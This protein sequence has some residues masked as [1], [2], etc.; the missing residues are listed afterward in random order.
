MNARLVA[1][2]NSTAA[3]PVIVI[4]GPDGCGKSTFVRQAAASLF[5]I[6]EFS[7]INIATDQDM[8]KLSS[9]RISKTCNGQR[10]LVVVKDIDKLSA[11]LTTLLQL[12]L[13]IP[14][15]RKR[16]QNISRSPLILVIS[17]RFNSKL[18]WLSNLSKIQL[19]AANI[20]VKR[21]AFRQMWQDVNDTLTADQQKQL[22]VDTSL[23]LFCHRAVNLHRL[24]V[25][26]QLVFHGHITSLNDIDVF[27]P[28]P[29]VDTSKL[30]RN[31]LGIAHKETGY[32]TFHKRLKFLPA[33]TVP[34]MIQHMSSNVPQDLDDLA[35]LK[36]GISLLDVLP[37]DIEQ[38]LYSGMSAAML[39][40][41]TSSGYVTYRRIPKPAIDIST[42]VEHIYSQGAEYQRASKFVSME[43][44]YFRKIITPMDYFSRARVQSSE[45]KKRNEIT[46]TVML[47][48]LK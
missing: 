2:I 13:K 43:T 41:R 25:I 14:K 12:Q 32:E 44:F 37:C 38:E 35:S 21:E 36:D 22:P 7:A 47:N 4:Q 40:P 34:A 26:L 23:D 24:A 33:S 31:V 39:A 17:D 16:R 10:N 15:K 18:F 45:L 46:E 30:I 27:V 11:R 5:N 29:E 6:V 9:L 8:L 3:N 19:P 42:V 28:V 48:Q 20:N 1:A